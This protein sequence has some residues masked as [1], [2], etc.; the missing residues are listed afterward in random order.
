MGVHALSRTLS[1]SLSREEEEELVRSNKK[2]KDARYGS[3][4]EAKSPGFGDGSPSPKASFKD[5]LVGVIPGAYTQA[6]NFLAGADE[7]LDSDNEILELREGIAV[8]KLSKEE[9]QRI[10]ALWA[11]TLIVKVF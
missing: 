10:R 5:K 1:H 11:K 8:V 2:V 3:F 9:K 7:D 6:F 4:N